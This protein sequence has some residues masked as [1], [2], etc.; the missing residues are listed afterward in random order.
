[1]YGIE[2][3]LISF[4]VNEKDA[5]NKTSGRQKIRCGDPK[6]NQEKNSED[7]K[8]FLIFRLILFIEA[9]NIK[10]TER[11]YDWTRKHQIT[12]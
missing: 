2:D 8:F 5:L 11:G 3:D 4:G 1:M 12:R 10:H 9:Y 7:L 6:Q